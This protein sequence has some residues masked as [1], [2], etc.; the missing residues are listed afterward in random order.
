MV[1]TVPCTWN[2]DMRIQS[3]LLACVGGRQVTVTWWDQ[4]YARGYAGT[5]GRATG[6]LGLQK[7]KK[8]E[9]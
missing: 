8:R 9:I 7:F 3:A 5:D 6:L 1:G 4:G 2:T